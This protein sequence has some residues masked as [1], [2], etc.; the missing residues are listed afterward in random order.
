MLSCA[1]NCT[2]PGIEA[3]KIA[4]PGFSLF[5]NSLIAIVTEKPARFAR[6]G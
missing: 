2:P 1:M 3:Q 5:W 6:A 4:P